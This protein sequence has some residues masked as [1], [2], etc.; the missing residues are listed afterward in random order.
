[1]SVEQELNRF[2]LGA[3]PLSEAVGVPFSWHFVNTDYL[4]QVPREQR[5]CGAAFCLRTRGGGRFTLDRCLRDHRRTAFR[6]ALLRRECFTMVCHAGAKLLAVPLFAG[7]VFVGVLF[8]GPVV[9]NSAPT[10]P[11]MSGEYRELPVR[12]EKELLALG[13]YLDGEFRRRLAD[14]VLPGEGGRLT[15]PLATAD[16]R[17]LRAAH[18]M[19][20]RR[21]GKV[22]ASGIAGACGISLSTLLHLFRRETGFRFRDWL[23]RLRVSDALSLIEG[24]DLPFNEIALTCGFSDQSR[25]TVLTKRYLG[26]TPGEL[27]RAALPR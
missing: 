6:Q 9:G 7:E 17:V 24:T 10:Y 12:G 15:P 23:M 2:A 5:Q 3:I 13:R 22:S 4:R 20:M 1:M 14:L 16:T 25:L 8:A 21:R 11:E 19:R 27:R 18:L 26:R